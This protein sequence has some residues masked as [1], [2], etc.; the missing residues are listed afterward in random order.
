MLHLRWLF[1]LAAL[2]L[3][4]PSWAQDTEIDW[5]APID[6]INQALQADIDQMPLGKMDHQG[7][8]YTILDPIAVAEPE[9]VQRTQTKV[10][11]PP[12]PSGFD[13]E[14]SG[15]AFLCI[16][17]CPPGARLS[18]KG[19]C[20][21]CP[22]PYMP[23]RKRSDWICLQCPPVATVRPGNVKDRETCVSGDGQTP[24]EREAARDRDMTNFLM[25]DALGDE[26]MEKL[27]N[28]N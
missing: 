22:D 11:L 1:L 21:T 20:V 8:I 14:V 5:S 23:A 18:A 16:G 3:S 25:R 12:C 27:G 7:R 4:A 26:M 15:D 10:E 28:Q 19:A 13:F 17:P 2:T 9:I 6:E 24:G